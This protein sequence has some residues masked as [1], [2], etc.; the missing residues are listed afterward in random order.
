MTPLWIWRAGE[1]LTHEFVRFKRNFTS[2]T[3]SVE[4]KLAADTDFVAYLDGKEI[5][6]GQFSD[7][8][9]EKTFS[10]FNDELSEGEHTLG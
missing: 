2:N 8:P 5:M 3:K 9:Q 1:T 10:V 4:I 7:Y 6:R